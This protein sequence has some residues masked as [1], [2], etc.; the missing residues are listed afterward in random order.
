MYRRAAQDFEFSLA[1]ANAIKKFDKWL[2]YYGATG[3]VLERVSQESDIRVAHEIQL[4]QIYN[5]DATIDYSS[6]IVS[7]V[8]FSLN[9]LNN[10]LRYS[11]LRNKEGRF[12]DVKYDTVHFSASCENVIEVVQRANE[13]I[14]PVPV[15]YKKA[16]VSGW[17]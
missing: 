7:N 17:V 4:N 2:V 3:E 6:K 15:N 5:E 10:L 8:D 12:T 13:I 11:T 1:I 9:R 14:S 16:V